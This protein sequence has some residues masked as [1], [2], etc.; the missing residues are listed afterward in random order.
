[1]LTWTIVAGMVFLASV[2]A[3]LAMPELNPTL[4]V[5]MGISSGTYLGFELPVTK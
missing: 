4:L 3:S 5:S 1:M 2:V